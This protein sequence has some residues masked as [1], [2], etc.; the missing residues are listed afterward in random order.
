MKQIPIISLWQPWATAVVT[1]HPYKHGGAGVIPV[2][3]NETRC[4]HTDFTGRVLVHAA[5]KWDK[6][7]EGIYNSWPFDE[8]HKQLGKLEFGRIVGAVEITG[9][10]TSEYWIYNHSP[11]V[12]STHE[13]F[14]MGDF[15]AGRFAFPLLNPIRFEESIPHKGQQ[16]K[17]MKVPA[18]ILPEK[19]HH[20]FK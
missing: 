2:K 3:Q 17:I 20:L 8:F 7:L 16:G 10:T 1:A 18:S 12:E 19:Y 14:H 6:K 13:E 5:K 9:C 11:E 4:W 15:S